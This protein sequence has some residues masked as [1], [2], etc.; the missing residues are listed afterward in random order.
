MYDIVARIIACV[1]HFCRDVSAILELAVICVIPVV[2]DVGQ[3]KSSIISTLMIHKVHA[4][5]NTTLLQVVNVC[6]VGMC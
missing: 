2:M 5:M 4:C 6:N 3:D 1:Q